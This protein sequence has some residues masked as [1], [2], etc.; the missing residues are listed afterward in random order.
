MKISYN[1]KTASAITSA[2][3]DD[4]VFDLAGKKVWAKG[5]R[6]GADYSD[7]TGT[8]SSLP[9]N[10]G[11]ADTV[12]SWHKDNI[13]WTGFITSGTAS[14][15][16]YWFKMY[17]VTI[18]DK[19]YNDI[20]LTFLLSEGYSS[21]FSIFQ[22]KFRQNG[23]NSSKAYNFSVHLRE[24]VGNCKDKIVAYYN[25][26]TGN[27]Q[28][29]GNVVSQYATMNYT[30]IKKTTRTA[31][32]FASLG[33]LTAQSFSSVQT[34]PDTKTGGYTKVTMTRV[35]QVAYAESA[36][37]AAKVT[38]T[39]KFKDINGAEVSYDGS[40][41]KDLTTGTYIAKLPYGFNSWASN[42]TWG[43]TTGTS[44]A[45]WN[46]STGGSI[47]FRRDNP[48]SG[49]MSI[50]VDGRVYVNEG[51][52]PVLSSESNNGFWGM[53]TPDGGN[54][55][56][57]TSDLGLIPYVSGGANNGHSSL[58]TS[59][60]YFSTAYIDKVYG[61]LI[62]NSDTATKL[63][64]SHKLWGNDFNG[65]Q[66]VNGNITFPSIGDVAISN[67]ISWDGSTDGAD[68]YYQT[69]AKDQG[70]LVLNVRDDAN[71]YIRL[72]LSG[73]FKSYFDVNKSYWS[74]K[75]ELANKSTAATYL[76]KNT[77]FLDDSTGRLSYYDTDFTN[78][79][80]N[81]AW[82]APS[83]AWYQIIHND[84]S[85]TGYW[86][87]LAFPVNSV[88]GLSWR[89]RR[90]SAFFGWYR[91]LDSN[92]FNGYFASADT[93]YLKLEKDSNT[94]VL[95]FSL[96]KASNWDKAYNWYDTITQSDTDATINKWGE[97]VNFLAGIDN[98]D[99]SKTLKTMLDSKLSVYTIAEKEDVSS[100]MNT[101]IYY[102]TT[103]AI[104]SS[105]ANSPFSNGFALLNVNSYSSGTDI[106]RSRLALNTYGEI[107][108]SDDRTTSGT[109]ETWYNV[110]TA[111]NSSID[112]SSN[113]ITINGTS[114][115]VATSTH[116][117][118]SKYVKKSGDTM[119]GALSFS[120]NFTIN[121][122]RTIN[123]EAD[124]NAHQ[125]QL[126]YP[127]HNKVDWYEYGGTW[128]FYST[129][130]KTNTLLV[131]LA[132]ASQ[133]KGTLTISSDNFGSLIIN[134]TNASAAASIAFKGGVAS[135]STYGS[136]GF[137]ASAKDGQLLRWNSDTSKVYTILDTSSTYV[138]SDGK[139]YINNKAITQVA[140]AS[141]ATEAKKLNNW[142]SSRIADLNQT[143]GDG[144][145]RIFNATSS[146]TANKCPADASI[147]HLA[148]DNI[149]GWD[150]QLAI[151]YDNIYFRGQNAKTWGAWYTVLHSNNVQVK[152]TA[153]GAAILNF[154]E[155]DGISLSNS[156]GNVTIANNKVYVAQH[157]ANDINYPLVW[158]NQPNS[159]SVWAQQ[160]H[161]SW[162]DLCYNPKTKKLTAGGF[163]HS[164][165]TDN[166]DSYYLTAGGGY[167]PINT[168][169]SSV[170]ATY[171]KDIAVT[172]EW[173]D[174][175]N[176]AG[177]VSDF[178][179]AT[180]TYIVQII[181]NNVVYSGVMSWSTAK[182][183][184]DSTD[185]IVLHRS[186]GGYTSTIYLRTKETSGNY[187]TMQ[188]SANKT[189][190]STT[191]KFNFQRIC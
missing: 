186:G 56:I 159:D 8:P 12:D 164:G 24:L 134:R 175:T 23:T 167:K 180:G 36:T 32:D 138:D 108:I 140:N 121:N 135:T 107:K 45:S 49:K 94:G 178:I 78:T 43:N 151:T 144:A 76:T 7:I 70:N 174:I 137:N 170:V 89:Q 44:F 26:T 189:L 92:N 38:S 19:Q 162:A 35:G 181:A 62:G 145:L 115:A 95:K 60:W 120:S 83:K 55:W 65:S 168:V 98:T 34:Q 105:L 176:F 21:N 5:V 112:T 124:N 51:N 141:L 187:M 113:K 148:W 147:L 106:R 59:S 103:D 69:T 122:L 20:T 127:G 27:I 1:P 91:I 146:T 25:N 118:D 2:E 116:N 119:T 22:F 52:N 163:K 9:A 131:K 3:N 177:N 61:S 77:D 126:G 156:N 183:T 46:D 160:L 132:A 139:G 63:T 152:G 125:L 14:L 67:K 117:H 17:D 161:K 123:N 188:I 184:A 150:T 47:D 72:A 157:T 149:G 11:N 166:A 87:E 29:W 173:K 185:E 64:T 33:S 153:I 142:F 182:S 6:I 102:S 110:L 28:L 133:F 93:S 100:L 58:G 114:L 84:L 37:S 39:I 155:G 97:I 143:F 13:Q 79:T 179:N 85:V 57:R 109:G 66:D 82:S 31:T 101:G 191:Y 74:G 73:E 81:A 86:T 165:L 50:K 96:P 80:N 16:S 40:A 90:N 75:S 41:V 18:T 68:I 171:S 154:K 158:S 4:I 128:N 15:S 42:C 111:K 169:M 190:S 136:I 54:D 104:S 129:E 88:D 53:R 172:A 10:G 71:A 48:S 99:T 130:T 30:V